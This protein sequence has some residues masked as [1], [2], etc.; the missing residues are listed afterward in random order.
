MSFALGIDLGTTYTAA[1]TYRDGRVEIAGLGNRAAAI[2]SVVLLREDEAVLTGEA[3]SRRG[4]TQPDRLAREF[5]RRV[6]DTNPIFLGGAPYSAEALMARLLQW[7]IAE[8]GAR[9]GGEPDALAVSHP[10]NWG[11]YKKDL[12]AQAVRL[13][14]LRD[15]TYLTEPEA[16][17]IHYAS[18][19]RVDAGDVVAVYDLGG[20]T[21]DAAV[22]RKSADEGFEILGQPEGVERLGGIDFDAAVYHHVSRSLGGKLEE[23]DE[24]DPAAIA[25][26]ARLRQECAEAKEALSNDT[27][28]AIPV[29]LP[30]VQTEVRLTRAEFEAMIRPSL[31]DSI[32]ALRRALDSAGVTPEQVSKVLLVGGSSRIPLV[33]QLVSADLGRPVAVD[34]DP[35]HAIALGT[36]LA[37]ARAG[38]LAAAAVPTVATTP[39][40]PEA[41]TSGPDAGAAAAAA[42]VAGL[43]AGAAGAAALAGDDTAAAPPPTEA[44][45][46]EPPPTAPAEPVAAGAGAAPAGGPPPTEAM[47]GS[48]GPMPPGGTHVEY[49]PPAAAGGPPTGEDERKK[50]VPLAAIAAGVVVVLL[51]IGGGIVL[52]AG[53][54]DDDDGGE[55]VQA[56]GQ[57]E[58][59]EAADDTAP[60]DTEPA[61]TGPALTDCEVGSDNTCIVNAF[62]DGDTIVVEYET[63]FEEDPGMEDP[64]GRHQHFFF[65]PPTEPNAAGSNAPDFGLEPGD[66]VVWA[67][68]SPFTDG[69][70]TLS[71]A[72]ALGAAE[73]CVRPAFGG[74]HDFTGEPGN[75]VEVASIG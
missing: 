34:A 3:A 7:V 67:G 1:A 26:G 8:V 12:L 54:G 58:V 28:V 56:G 18:Q 59:T 68:G 33:A 38:G 17:A 61:D 53:G 25:A 29:L 55:D 75:C 5:K 46:V 35:K 69:D 37:A 65:N 21:F 32:R 2:P 31:Q 60:E 72:Q 27:D 43:A 10:A 19:E 64:A 71:Q 57:T 52:A 30:N 40:E 51:L 48:G 16:A 62:L 20:G 24:D 23:L 13:A 41:A 45:P 63:A 9:Q 73:L 6:G 36:A 39:E 14:D 44:A 11:Q 4:L 22:L 49:T 66:W 47:V 15:A 50:K 42:G 70:M 74:A